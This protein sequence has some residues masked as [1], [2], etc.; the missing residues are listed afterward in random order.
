M[1]ENDTR[2]IVDNYIDAVRNC[3]GKGVGNRAHERLTVLSY[4]LPVS[5]L[6]ACFPKTQLA[7]VV[8]EHGRPA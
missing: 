3:R 7:I 5:T 6:Y 4:H 1:N 2:V 8:D